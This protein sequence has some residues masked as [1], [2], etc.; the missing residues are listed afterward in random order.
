M[1]NR[2]KI[3]LPCPDEAEKIREDCE[4]SSPLTRVVPLASEEQ[5][6]RIFS[7]QPS[8]SLREVLTQVRKSLGRRNDSE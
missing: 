7:K 8:I 5:S 4:L 1:S 6:D 3:L 2:S